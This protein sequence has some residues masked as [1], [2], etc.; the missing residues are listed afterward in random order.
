LDN[1]RFEG[2]VCFPS[3]S[4]L[5]LG[6]QN[7]MAS[8]LTEYVQSTFGNQ[9]SEDEAIQLCLFIFCTVEYLPTELKEIKWDRAK[10]STEFSILSQ[11][12]LISNPDDKATSASYWNDVITQFMMNKIERR[13]AFRVIL[14]K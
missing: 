2:E 12:G 3:G 9:M 14:S 4:G 1:A 6:S 8:V 7:I 5:T 10:I 11:Q 13:E